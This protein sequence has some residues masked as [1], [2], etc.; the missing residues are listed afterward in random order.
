MHGGEGIPYCRLLQFLRAHSIRLGHYRTQVGTR[1][2][3]VNELRHSTM[4]IEIVL[5]AHQESREE[6]P[7]A[8]SGT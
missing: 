5:L 4:A 2:E 3:L 8:A 6:K 7:S 1:S